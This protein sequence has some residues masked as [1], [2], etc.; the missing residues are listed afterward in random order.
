VSVF[1][2]LNEE[3]IRNSTVAALFELDSFAGVTLVTL[4]DQEFG[5]D[6]DLA[7]LLELGS[8]E[9]IEQFLLA[10]NPSNV[11]RGWP[12]ENH[13]RRRVIA[14]DRGS[15]HD[16]RSTPWSGFLRNHPRI[17]GHLPESL[18][19]ECLAPNN[20]CDTDKPYTKPLN[21]LLPIEKNF[22]TVTWSPLAG[23]VDPVNWHYD[24]DLFTTQDQPGPSHSFLLVDK[25]VPDAKVIFIGA[26]ALNPAFTK[27][28]EK[29]IFLQMWDI[30]DAR[31]G[32][33][34]T[35]DRAI[36]VPV[37]N[38]SLLADAAVRWAQILADLT[39]PTKRMTVQQAVDDVNASDTV[40]QFVVYGNTGIKF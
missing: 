15:R 4:I 40:Q 33:A 29:P 37:G 11:A 8:F 39:K 2:T 28:G 13:P 27:P 24:N 31:F 21:T 10:K 35:R 32:K 19:E 5:V 34:E 6:V 3:E 18:P 1:P 36:I 20:T 25:L 17:L 7:D 38:T 9:A 22:N 30:D 26:C 12:K 14:S 23:G 16:K